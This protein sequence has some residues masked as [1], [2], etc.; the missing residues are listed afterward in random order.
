MITIGID[1]HSR[2][3][4]AAAL[5]DGGRVLAEITVGS[6]GGEL[7]RLVR[8]IEG[9]GP[10]R[11]VAIEGARG[12][13]LALC[14]RVLAAGETV[15]DVAP[16]LTASERRSSRRA[17]KDDR[18]DAVAVARVALREEGLPHASAEVRGSNLKLLVDARDQLVAEAT[19]TRNRLHALLLTIAPGYHEQVRD[20]TSSAALLVARRLA[21]RARGTDRVRSSLACSAITRLR[22]LSGEIGVLEREITSVLDQAAPANLLSICGVGPLVGAKILGEVR[23][24]GRFSSAAAFASYSGTAP[25]PASS[26]TIIRHRLHR[27]GNR[28]LNRALHTV[29]LTQARRDDRAKQFLA[30]K[31]AEGKTPREARRA[32]KRHLASA[33][34]RAL[35]LDAEEVS[36]GT[37]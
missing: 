2:T 24:V 20:L 32:L 22:S 16:A 11:I 7:D 5:D 14:R 17:G 8:W 34:H 31:R 33:V 15:L 36:S 3:H 26:G 6:G 30:R 37:A 4:S 13:G 19:R 28:Q 25:I 9:V 21:S 1:P 27:G 23:D 10:E 35:L 12:F 18:G 29:A